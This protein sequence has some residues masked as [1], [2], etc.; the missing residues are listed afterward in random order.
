MASIF[1]S[2]NIGYSGLNAAQVGIDTTGHNIANAETEGYTRQRVVTSEATPI[3]ITPGARGN[4]AQIAEIVRVF[5]SFVNDRYS[6]AA[7]NKEYSDTL[8][9]NLEEVSSYFP[10]IDN[11]GFKEDL[12][13]YF[14]L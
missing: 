10:D 7:Q 1:N 12:K 3:A 14:D 11:L 8:K 4:G 2:L 9:K 6:T 5:D 13:N